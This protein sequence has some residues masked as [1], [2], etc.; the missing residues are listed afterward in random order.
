MCMK[1]MLTFRNLINYYKKVIITI[2]VIVTYIMIQYLL[3]N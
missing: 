2:I 3:N 1:L